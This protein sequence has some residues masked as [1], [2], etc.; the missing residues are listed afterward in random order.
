MNCG[1]LKQAPL[2]S[3]STIMFHVTPIPERKKGRPSQLPFAFL[4]QFAV[5]ALV[6]LMFVLYVS[7]LRMG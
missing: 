4:A 5:V 2:P 1:G 3:K 6:I 7:G